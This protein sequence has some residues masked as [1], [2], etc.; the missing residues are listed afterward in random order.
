MK[1]MPSLGAFY[2]IQQGD[3]SVWW[4][5]TATEALGLSF[6]LHQKLTGFFV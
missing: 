6:N 5:S 4:Y 1:L 2:A 3:G